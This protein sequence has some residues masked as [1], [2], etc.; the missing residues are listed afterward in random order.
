MFL[1]D[2]FGRVMYERA[3]KIER[4]VVADKEGRLVV[5]CGARF[6]RWTYYQPQVYF[7]HMLLLSCRPDGFYLILACPL[8]LAV[9]GFSANH[10]NTTFATLS[11]STLITR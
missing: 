7:R 2:E 11:D 6:S 1:R 3:P 4:E 9:C 8:L 5:I 10:R